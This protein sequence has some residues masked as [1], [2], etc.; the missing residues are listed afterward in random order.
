MRSLFLLVSAGGRDSADTHPRRLCLAPP[1]S[2]ALRLHISHPPVR[3]PAPK[4]A[5]NLRPCCNALTHPPYSPLFFFSPRRSRWRTLC[6]SRNSHRRRTASPRSRRSSPSNSPRTRP[7]PPPRAAASRRRTATHRTRSASVKIASRS[8]VRRSPLDRQG[9]LRITAARAAAATHV[10]RA[11]MLLVV[12]VAGQ[13]ARASSKARR[14]PRPAPL[15]PCR[16]EARCRTRSVD[17][18]SRRA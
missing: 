5:L 11:R 9:A 8:P 18:A 10:V 17:V 2:P 14:S 12:H 3:S 4:P 1:L 16:A 7:R 13:A 6:P 15:R